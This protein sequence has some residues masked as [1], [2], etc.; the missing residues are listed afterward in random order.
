VV[1]ATNRDLESEIDA[2]RF[3]H[4]LYYRINVVTIDAPPLRSRGGDVLLLA[5][6]FIQRIA[7]RSGKQV[8]G[9]SVDAARMFLEYDWPGNVRELENCLEH[10]VAM[11]RHN[12]IT[13]ND[14]PAKIRE[15]RTSRIVI[16]GNDPDELM[17]L[18]QLENRYVHRVLAACGGNKTRAAKVLGIDR[19]SLYRRLEETPA[20]EGQAAGTPGPTNGGNG[21]PTPPVSEPSAASS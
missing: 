17:T 10:A 5:M 2:G 15:H 7:Q 21:T 8:T 11:S 19:R 18:A 3:R 20:I 1:C 4:D 12:E 13:P 6:H 16:E 14:L 9:L